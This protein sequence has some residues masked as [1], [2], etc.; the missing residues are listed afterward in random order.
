MAF[1]VEFGAAL[2]DAPS[3]FRHH[4]DMTAFPRFNGITCCGI[5]TG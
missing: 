3:D 5:I 1:P 2:L 4:A